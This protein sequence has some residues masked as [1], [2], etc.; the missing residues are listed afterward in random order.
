METRSLQQKFS[1]SDSRQA[2][3]TLLAVTLLLGVSIVGCRPAALG[4]PGPTALFQTE[5]DALHQEYGFPGATAA[6]ILSNGTAG[7]VA[8]GLSDIEKGIRMSP[9]SRMLAA[10]IG[11]TFVSATVLA[12]AQE[13]HLDLDDP[14]SLWL[15]DKPWFERLPNHASITVRHL[16]A[17]TAGISNHVDEPAFAAAFAANW[18]KPGSPFSPEMLVEYV[19]DQ[20]PLFAPGEGWSYS[21]TGY[22]LVGLIIEEVAGRDYYVEV[23]ERFLTPLDLRLTSASNQHDLTGL[24]AG[25]MAAENG[26]GLPAKTTLDDGRMAWN[27]AIEWTG[28][29]LASNSLDLAKWAKALFE[30]QAMEGSYLGDLLQDA[31]ISAEMQD[32]SYGA[33]VAIYKTGPLGPRYG[34]SGW[35]PGYSSS[36]RYYPDYRVA[37]A[38]QIN[39]DIGIVDHSTALYEEMAT[40][41][42]QVIAAIATE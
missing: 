31:P 19:L 13:G 39:T 7:V 35:I 2:L 30:G 11:K 5:L 16:L 26:F 20:P 28:G 21:D 15:S 33:G 32:I 40:R 23:R 27:P 42:E 18:A 9:S 36:L 1:K 8:T 29:G 34:H 37:I 25:Y 17:H 22:L 3:P 12:L 41:L 6:Y 4:D 24:A 10:S 38:F 14:I